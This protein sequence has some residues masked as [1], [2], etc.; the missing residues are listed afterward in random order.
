MMLFQPI[1]FTA[2]DKLH[3][4]ANLQGPLNFT[5]AFISLS[6]SRREE[7]GSLIF[8]FYPRSSEQSPPSPRLPHRATDTRHY[9]SFF[10][11]FLSMF[12]LSF[13]EFLLTFLSFPFGLSQTWQLVFF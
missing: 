5:I 8:S 4:E 3:V 6:C 1:D 11:Y 12:A 7:M 10:Y 9:G 13:Y 2:R